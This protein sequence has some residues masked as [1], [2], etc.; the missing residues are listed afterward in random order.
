MWLPESIRG[1]PPQGRGDGI[2]KIA[3]FLENYFGNDDAGNFA[4]FMV[5]VLCMSY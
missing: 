5:D 4:I 2:L 1:L 3:Y